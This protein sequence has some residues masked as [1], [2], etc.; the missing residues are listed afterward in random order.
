VFRL[1]ISKSSTDNFFFFFFF[2][3]LFRYFTATS[4]PAD[5]Q[6]R[7]LWLQGFQID[8]IAYG[9][10]VWSV[11]YSKPEDG[12]D[13]AS[14]VQTAQQMHSFRG[15]DALKKL[16]THL[17]AQWKERRIAHQLVYGDGVWVCLT[18]APAADSPILSSG[19]DLQ[20]IVKSSSFPE[21]QISAN[22]DRGMYIRSMVHDGERFVLLFETGDVPQSLYMDKAFP[23]AEIEDLWQDCYVCSNLV[24]A[25]NK[26]VLV[27]NE[28]S[29]NNHQG[30][31]SDTIFPTDDL[32]ELLCAGGL[33][34]KLVS[35]CA[36]L[37]AFDIPM[38]I[39]IIFLCC[40]KYNDD[41][42]WF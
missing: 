36:K 7:A 32:D 38:M 2:L 4:V 37:F 11:L 33:Q 16:Q 24:F 41:K 10:G 18:Y 34:P 1:Q 42:Q 26:W 29:R 28:L 23:E 9:K 12:Y 40:R 30:W 15:E 5:A 27:S 6:L 31:V 21:E 19:D 17:A 20:L 39:I 35:Y 22:W 13:D 25:D 8:L 14:R 3:F